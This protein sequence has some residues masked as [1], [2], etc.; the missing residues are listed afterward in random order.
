MQP[1]GESSK[2]GKII[3]DCCGEELCRRLELRGVEVDRESRCI[4]AYFISEGMLEK[5]QEAAIG[6]SLRKAPAGILAAKEWKY[7]WKPP[8]LELWPKRV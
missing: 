5:A 2:L 1:M 7:F 4:N 3:Y 6:E 8:G